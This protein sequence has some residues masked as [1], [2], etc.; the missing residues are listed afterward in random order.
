MSE[1]FKNNFINLSCFIG[2]QET[3][4]LK[5]NI[6]EYKK[7]KGFQM[8]NNWRIQ[9]SI[10]L[11]TL[12]MILTG[13][14][15]FNT[16]YNAKQLF[17]ES[18][19]AYGEEEKKN[20][21]SSKTI[22]SLNEAAAKA[23][24]VIMKFPNSKYVDDAMYY[25]GVCNFQLGK[26]LIARKKLLELTLEYPESE[27]FPQAQ[28]WIA[29]CYFRQNKKD[30]AFSLLERFIK[31]KKNRKY[32]SDAMSLAGYLALEEEDDEKTFSYFNQA[33][34]NTEDRVEKS[35]LLYNLAVIYTDKNM[36]ND[37]LTNLEKVVKIS[38]DPSLLMD[39]K[40]QYIKVYRLQKR[41]AKSKKLIEEMLG[42]LDYEKIWPQLEVELGLILYYE[43][44]S[45]KA[46]L[47]Y[48]SV[49]KDHKNTSSASLAAYYLGEIYLFDKMDFN[50]A[51]NYY[52][53]VKSD[54]LK[55]GIINNADKKNKLISNYLNI[56]NERKQLVKEEPKLVDQP[57][58]YYNILID[59]SNS[60]Y[61][62][63]DSSKIDL[64]KIDLSKVDSSK[65]DLLGI[66]S[67]KIDSSEMD[68]SKID[69][70]RLRKLDKFK[71]D[72]NNYGQIRFN[73]AEYYVF[74]FE[75]VDSALSIYH[76]TI[77]FFPYIDIMP[78]ILNTWAFVLETEKGDKIK[79]DSL[80]RLMVEKFPGSPLTYHYLGKQN[81]DSVRYK[82]DQK[83]IYEIERGFLNKEKY[84]QA[85]D[86]FQNL[87][88]DG[89]L[90]STSIAHTYYQ[91]AWLYDYELIKIDSTI[92]EAMKY[93]KIIAED[94][95]KTQ[96]ASI[97]QKR[98]NAITKMIEDKTKAIQDTSKSVE[99]EIQTDDEEKL[100]KDEFFPKERN[101]IKK[102]GKEQDIKRPKF[103]RK[104]KLEE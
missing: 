93:Y 42:N 38:K 49:L 84:S 59:T 64:Y 67:S 77:S 62:F 41:Y 52:K 3:K 8:K 5:N 12:I 104:R 71:K 26:Y 86:R 18:Q 13:C 23:Q 92:D 37:A 75:A 88:L 76:N 51:K 40:L 45:E 103:I 65:T 94:F 1:Y 25:Y 14:A 87:I 29:K 83:Q 33:I 78:Q 7:V 66:D 31:D 97:S 90:D 16:F 98:I 91:I 24:K 80:H 72:A 61:S 85:I 57:K 34:I 74:Y 36:F 79:A 30:M 55:K 101:R 20:A 44:Q 15:Y 54:E 53:K 60:N 17:K 100:I 27:Y 4:S 6:N 70:L 95:P 56:E 82:K 50:K 46:I 96:F 89:S 32:F 39:V 22:K 99:Q 2:K 63:I 21:L 73:E 47:K 68:F 35:Q 19:T 48:E 102:I 58:E 28:L 9:I 43:K 10:I 11:F 69:S 81:P